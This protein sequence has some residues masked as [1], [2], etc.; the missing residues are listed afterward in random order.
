MQGEFEDC[1][2]SLWYF[3]IV[4]HP[5]SILKKL[6]FLVIQMNYKTVLETSNFNLTNFLFFLSNKGIYVHAG[7]YDGITE[8][9]PYCL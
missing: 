2:K 5:T 7:S 6:L 8:I 4:F 1:G 3:Y 9:V